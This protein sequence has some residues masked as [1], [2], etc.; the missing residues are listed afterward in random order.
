MQKEYSS[1]RKL[2]S[3]TLVLVFNTQA[4]NQLV[5]AQ[6]DDSKQFVG[7]PDN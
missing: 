3:H 6:I 4:H 5:I 7:L 2:K 1:T